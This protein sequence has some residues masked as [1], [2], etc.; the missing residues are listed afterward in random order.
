MLDA[1]EVSRLRGCA[2]GS[3]EMADDLRRIV[4]AGKVSKKVQAELASFAKR[5]DYQWAALT[6]ACDKM[7]GAK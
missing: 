3:A 5:L 4:A 6:R 1:L 2:A 7:E